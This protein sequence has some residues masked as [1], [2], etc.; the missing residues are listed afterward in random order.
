M[1]LIGELFGSRAYDAADEHAV[2]AHDG[3]GHDDGHGHGHGGP[4]VAWL[5]VLPVAAIMLM[6]PPALGS[7]AVERSGAAEA[8]QPADD[9]PA[10]TGSNPVTLSLR[11]YV[12]RTLWAEG[13]TLQGRTVRL[14]GFITG[15]GNQ[16]YL[17]RIAI[18]CCA[19]DGQALRIRLTGPLPTGL[20]P[21][22]WVTVTGRY[23]GKPATD[24][25]SDE[26]IPTL[27]VATLERVAA[28]REPYDG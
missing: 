28:P 19:T 7:Y 1:T 3:H 6:G 4:A 27:A 26:T 25:V 10:L 16:P 13:K 8:L 24:P 12:D 9:Y 20:T 5:L 2:L 15:G 21:D 11:E 22:T 18:S 23:D 14:T 17:T